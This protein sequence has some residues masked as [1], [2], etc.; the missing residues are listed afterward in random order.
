MDKLNLTFTLALELWLIPDARVEMF[1]AWVL[2]D[3]DIV[4]I[5]TFRLE[6]ETF[7][8]MLLDC[9]F[10]LYDD[11]LGS[12]DLISR[13]LHLF[14]AIIHVNSV[15]RFVHIAKATWYYARSLI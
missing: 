9:N 5:I 13:E 14:L 2:F 8:L 12:G 15:V 7:A 10:W 6:C 3:G 4:H 1:L 11:F